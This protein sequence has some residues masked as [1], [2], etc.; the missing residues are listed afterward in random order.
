MNIL[1]DDRQ[2]K[3]EIDEAIV[4]SMEKA[5]VEVLEY[6]KEPLDF[7]V[8]LSFVTNEEIHELNK[9]YRNVDSETDVLSFPVDQDFLF[10]GG[11]NLL[12]D[13]II[14]IEK[15]VEQA[16]EYGHSFEREMVYLTVHSIFHLLGYDHMDED[17]KQIMREK[18][19]DIM[20]ILDINR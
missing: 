9:E 8:S 7:E 5:I 16:R 2:N 18:E 14:S 19:E 11:P 6:E 3:V 4:E 10:E 15:A 13:V 20:T 12:G 17:E 1:I